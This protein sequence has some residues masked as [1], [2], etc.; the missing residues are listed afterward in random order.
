[1]VFNKHHFQSAIDLFSLHLTC[2]E[3]ML[4]QQDRS[5]KTAKDPSWRLDIIYNIRTFGKHLVYGWGQVV[6]TT[7]ALMRSVVELCIRIWKINLR[8]SSVFQKQ[9]P[10]P[11]GSYDL[12]CLW[13]TMDKTRK[14]RPQLSKNWHYTSSLNVGGSQFAP[15]HFFVIRDSMPPT[16]LWNYY[17]SNIHFAVQFQYILGWQ[18]QA[19]GQHQ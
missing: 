2:L 6:K 4:W 12:R 1:M 9:S 14:V 16:C 17:F 10:R 7:W 11:D 18:V 8:V 19:Q 5:L 15:R 3:Y 13:G